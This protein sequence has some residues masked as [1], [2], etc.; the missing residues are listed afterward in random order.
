MISL[1]KHNPRSKP[2]RSKDDLSKG[3]ALWNTAVAKAIATSSPQVACRSI[4]IG[5]S[6]LFASD[7]WWVIFFRHDEPPILF[8]YYDSDVRK[9]RYEDG[10]YLLDP[11]YSSF[12]RGDPQGSYLKR[13]ISPKDMSKIELY[14]KYDSELFGPMDEIGLVIDIDSRTRSF[15]CVSRAKLHNNYPAY[16]QRHIELFES[17]API[18]QTVTEKIWT[19][20]IKLGPE[21]QSRRVAK[22]SQIEAFFTSFGSD[23]LTEREMEVGNLMIK[24]FNAREISTF[25]NITYGTARN[26]I[27]KVYVKLEVSSQSELCGLFIEQLLNHY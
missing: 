2:G 11:F 25:L 20:V 1:Q 13:E 27:K 9:D 15:V 8:D 17:I 5:L 3:Y 4:G 10:P 7:T 18:I 19:D 21:T 23:R 14:T 24:G 26:H 6:Q 22:H 12:L 16:A